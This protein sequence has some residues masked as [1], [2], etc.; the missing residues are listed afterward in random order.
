M[1]NNYSVYWDLTSDTPSEIMNLKV[2]PVLPKLCELRT[3]L[4]FMLSKVRKDAKTIFLTS[5]FPKEGKTLFPKF[6]GHFALSGK[7][8]LLIGMD[9][10]KPRLD[11]SI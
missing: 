8:V 3:N 2:G 9:I 11:E 5:T 1:E 6:G 7:K 10:R 4:E